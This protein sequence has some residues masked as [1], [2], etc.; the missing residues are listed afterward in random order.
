LI[1]LAVQDDFHVFCSL[2]LPP[3]PVKPFDSRGSGRVRSG[4][5]RR[6]VESKDSPVS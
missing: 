6:R 3:G 2:W 4:Q 5:A 1:R